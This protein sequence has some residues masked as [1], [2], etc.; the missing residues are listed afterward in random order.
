MEM[1]RGWELG[2]MRSRLCLSCEFLK[3][4][5]ELRSG[6]SLSG[7]CTQ[8]LSDEF[9]QT[10]GVNGQMPHIVY[11]THMCMYVFTFLM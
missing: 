4:T 11:H 8:Q 9:Q 5:E 3:R 10:A 1:G 2:K 6:T 7:L